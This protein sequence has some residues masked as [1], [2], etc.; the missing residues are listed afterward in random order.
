MNEITTL[1][2]TKV[3]LNPKRQLKSKSI[4]RKRKY[5]HSWCRKCF[6][7]SSTR[8]SS[9]RNQKLNKKP[10]EKKLSMSSQIT[11]LEKSFRNLEAK[12][13]CKLRLNQKNN[14]KSQPSISTSQIKLKTEEKKSQ[15]NNLLLLT[16]STILETAETT[17]NSKILASII[18]NGKKFKTTKNWILK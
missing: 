12:K 2:K 3:T 15:S 9:Y 11:L 18:P 14:K 5:T 16:R 10:P 17:E 1:I 4:R 8:E 7:Q 6:V 13:R